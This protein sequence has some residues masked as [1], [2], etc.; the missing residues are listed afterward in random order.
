MTRPGRLGGES[1]AIAMRS[2]AEERDEDKI[3]PRDVPI[4]DYTE[5]PDGLQ[6]VGE[7]E[8]RPAVEDDPDSEPPEKTGP[9]A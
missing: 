3:I 8:D 9:T 5:L 4:D 7:A 6:E 1:D 2:G